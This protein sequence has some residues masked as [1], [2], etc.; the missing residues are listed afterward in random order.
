MRELAPLTKDRQN[1]VFVTHKD[2]ESLIGSQLY[3]KSEDD[4]IAEYNS[5]MVT[6][7]VVFL[8]M[9][10][11]TT[12]GLHWKQYKGAPFFAVDVTPKSSFQEEAD[13]VIADVERRGHKFA[14]GRVQSLNA[15]HGMSIGKRIQP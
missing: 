7:L 6:P 3:T 1:L 2:I 10:E 13:G 5:S 15:P 14:E 11:H 12:D 9:D 4:L 8:G